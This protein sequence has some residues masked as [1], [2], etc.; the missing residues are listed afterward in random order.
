MLG[1]AGPDAGLVTLPSVLFCLLLAVR[2]SQIM[3]SMP[4]SAPPLL[5]IQIL[6][7]LRVASLDS[8]DSLPVVQAQA[9]PGHLLCILPPSAQIDSLDHG[10]VAS[11]LSSCICRADWEDPHLP[12]RA[13]RR[14]Q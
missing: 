10:V 14:F 12:C 3:C 9:F 13:L 7:K 2:L 8:R 4:L 11:N 1:D 6:P 5:D